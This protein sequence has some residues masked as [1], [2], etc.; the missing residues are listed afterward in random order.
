MEHN[1]LQWLYGPSIPHIC[2][3]Q[4]SEPDQSRRRHPKRFYYNRF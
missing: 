2:G 4:T 3:T 1:P